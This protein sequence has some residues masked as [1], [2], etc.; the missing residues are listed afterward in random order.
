MAERPGQVSRRFG[1][2]PFEQ[3]L[4]PA[5]ELARD[6]FPVS[7]VIARLWQSGLDK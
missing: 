2:L 3:L 1:K 7:P 4:R 5:I 6:G